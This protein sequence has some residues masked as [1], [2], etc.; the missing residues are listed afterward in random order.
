MKKHFAIIAAVSALALPAEATSAAT[1]TID[2]AGSS[3]SLEETGS[4]VGCGLT[5]CGVTANLAA[6]LDGMTFDLTNPGETETF[7]FLTF[8]GD[9]SGLATYDI[10]ANLAFVTPDVSATG[11]GTSGVALFYGSIAGGTLS[12]DS[13]VPAQVGF[14]DG[15]LATINFE[16][17]TG[18]FLG[19]TAT[20]AASVKLDVAPIPLPAAGWMLL[21]GLGGI[22]AMKRRKKV[23]A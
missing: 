17:G 16:G 20:T 6:G 11:S 14:G 18:I 22:A 3:V 19:D 2:G 10:T 12:W 7:D 9:G 8:T 5:N 23:D 13:G 15:G 21:A 4:G 1:F